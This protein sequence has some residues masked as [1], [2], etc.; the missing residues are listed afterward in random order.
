[1]NLSEAATATVNVNWTPLLIV[2]TASAVLV[3]MVLRTVI[4]QVCS[5]ITR[6]VDDLRR[7]VVAKLSS[8]K[9]SA[10]SIKIDEPN[11]SKK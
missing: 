10:Y 8:P 1:M 5:S 7:E 11:G 3:T 6:S 9:W 2:I 4:L